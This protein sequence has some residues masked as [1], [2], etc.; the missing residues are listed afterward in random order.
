MLQQ[1][2]NWIL[3]CLQ[4]P[5]IKAHFRILWSWLLYS[6]EE[7]DPWSSYSTADPDPTA[8]DPDPGA[9]IPDPLYLVTTLLYKFLLKTKVNWDKPVI[10]FLS[11]DRLESANSFFDICCVGV[12]SWSRKPVASVKKISILYCKGKLLTSLSCQV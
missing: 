8:C 2:Y 11:A 5:P 7:P 4:V 12:G 9:V 10:G 1:K 3:K 6:R